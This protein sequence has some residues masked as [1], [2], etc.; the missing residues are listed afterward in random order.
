MERSRSTCV[1]TL[2]RYCGRHQLLLLGSIFHVFLILKQ[3]L[4]RFIFF[5]VKN[6]FLALWMEMWI[7]WSRLKYLNNKRDAL[8]WHLGLTPM[9]ILLRWPP[10]PP[11]QT[12][13]KLLEDVPLLKGFVPQ[14]SVTVRLLAFRNRSLNTE[15]ERFLNIIGT[16]ELE[17]KTWLK[18]DLVQI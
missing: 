10:T 11:R 17:N 12:Q 18:R 1:W 5:T 7:D 3:L 15:V 9:V 14:Q 16:Y 8:P 6:L 4:L 13:R 2:L